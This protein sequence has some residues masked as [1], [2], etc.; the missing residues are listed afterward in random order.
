[1]TATAEDIATEGEKL[2]A[3]ILTRR[4]LKC[5]AA[6]DHQNGQPPDTPEHTKCPRCGL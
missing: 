4:R 1:M 3:A 5:I 6:G 2:A